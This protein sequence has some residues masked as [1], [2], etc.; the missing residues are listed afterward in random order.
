[1]WCVIWMTLPKLIHNKNKLQMTVTKVSLATYSGAQNGC[2]RWEIR[3][4]KKNWINRMINRIKWVWIVLMS[5]KIFVFSIVVCDID[6]QKRHLQSVSSTGATTRPI[7]I[8][9]EVTTLLSK[10]CPNFES[11]QQPHR[12]QKH[13]EQQFFSRLPPV[14]AVQE[15]PIVFIV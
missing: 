7:D 9:L 1:M 12:H 13:C 4:F 2:N 15:F 14:K 10:F 6:I 5:C 11:S 3:F 8:G